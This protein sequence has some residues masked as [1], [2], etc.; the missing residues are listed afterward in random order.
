[1]NL[2]KKKILFI[3]PSLC[4]AG[5]ETQTINLVNGLDSEQYEK[6]FLTFEK[7]IDQMGRIDKAQIKFFQYPRKF[8]FDLGPARKIATLIEQEEIDLVHCSLQISLFMGWLGIKFSMRKPKLV[9]AVHTT[10]NRSKRYDLIDKYFYQWL[11]RSCD[12]VVFVC[13]A[14][15]MH[16]VSKFP[17]L[18]RCATVIYN[19]VDVD[20]FDLKGF[21][22][23]GSILKAELGIA[24]NSKVICHIAG[25]RPEKGHLILL[26]AF[27]KALEKI[28]NVYLILV[29]DGEL[30]ETIMDLTKALKIKERVYFMGNV[31]DVRPVLAASDVSVLASVAV[32]TFSIAMLESMSMQV[33]MVA[34][35][36]GG[37][38]EAVLHNETGLIVSPGD[39]NQLTQALISILTHD[40]ERKLMGKLSRNLVKEKFL[41]TNMVNRTSELI[42]SALG[43]QIP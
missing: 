34:T 16:W 8:K 39:Y 11:M 6:F 29:G 37:T 9:L 32:E 12:R 26:R 2:P 14:Q 3:L 25:F 33:P 21:L 28:P 24:E 23:A 20:F 22:K 19:G 43:R 5:A 1:M 17:F 42:T 18:K 15:E 36:M 40:N 30:H 35:D 41:N 38:A 13:K 7:N 27:E 4:R 10:I 31:S